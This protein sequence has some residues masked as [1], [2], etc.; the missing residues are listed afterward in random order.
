MLQ[1]GHR[2]WVPCR[3]AVLNIIVNLSAASE[4]EY[5]DSRSQSSKARWSFGDRDLYGVAT[6][7]FL[8][9]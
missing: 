4:L 5:Y 8:H 2:K 3:L 6:G 9:F 1:Q 7:N